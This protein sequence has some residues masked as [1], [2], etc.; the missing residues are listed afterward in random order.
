MNTYLVQKLN[1]RLTFW[2][3]KLAVFRVILWPSLQVLFS[4]SFVRH[5]TVFPVVLVITDALMIVLWGWHPLA[6]AVAAWCVAIE[7][8]VYQGLQGLSSPLNYPMILHSCAL[9]PLESFLWLFSSLST[10][11]KTWVSQW[12]WLLHPSHRWGN[13][14]D[15]YSV[16]QT[17][18]SFPVLSHSGCECHPCKLF[19]HF[20]LSPVTC[21]CLCSLVI[22]APAVGIVTKLL[23][24]SSQG[25]SFSK[26]AWKRSEVF[27]NCFILVVCSLFLPSPHLPVSLSPLHLF[28]TSPLLLFHCPVCLLS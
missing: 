6:C 14:R 25:V 16:I 8:G 27:D 5:G 13:S 1:Q 28:I 9:C 26:S 3:I 21:Q 17:A 10:I 15:V 12:T 7:R 18:P 11:E 2:E 22:F 24:F 19:P 20:L 4:R 23:N